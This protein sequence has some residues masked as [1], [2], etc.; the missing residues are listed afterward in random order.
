[1]GLEREATLA[2]A[3]LIDTSAGPIRVVVTSDIRSLKARWERLQS[4]SP[5]TAVQT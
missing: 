3:L 2:P 4:F 1:L 5:C